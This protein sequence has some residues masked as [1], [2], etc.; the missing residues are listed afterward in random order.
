MLAVLARDLHRRAARAQPHLEDVRLGRLVPATHP[1]HARRVVDGEQLEHAQAGRREPA[2]QGAVGAAALEPRPRVVALRE[3]QERAPALDPPGRAGRQVEP[4]GVALDQQRARRAGGLVHGEQRL[5]GLLA[6]H[7]QQRERPGGRPLDAAQVRVLRVV[8]LDGQ[9]RRA[10]HREQRQRDQRVG[11]ARAR[12][13]ELDR[14]GR[15]LERVGDAQPLDRA[16]VGALREHAPRVGT[17]PPTLE[18]RH[19]LLRHELGRAPRDRARLGWR[20]PRFG[21]ARHV[22]HGHAAVAHEADTRAVGREPRVHR[23]GPARRQLAHRAARALDHE[24]PPRERHEHPRPVAR[25]RVRGDAA[26]RQAQALAARL[27]LDAEP[28]LGA[29]QQRLGGEQHAFAAAARVE[30]VQHVH[31]VARA[32]A[33]V[34]HLGAVGREREL[35]RRA[36]AEAVGGRVLVERALGARRAGERRGQ[37]HGR[38]GGQASHGT[39]RVSS[40]AGARRGQPSGEPVARETRG[41]GSFTTSRSGV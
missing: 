18:A 20:A 37:Q 40:C 39:H 27:L 28:L 9:G 33:Q 13:G 22:D 31:A 29:A 10:V 3:P 2:L 30:R 23:A 16:L 17:P 4:H 1:R 21:P 5:F 41:R 14:I 32:R 34:E 35:A 25:E 6:V 11:A 24:Q 38:G 36:R 8:P 7:D 15:G 19:F 26:R 12:I